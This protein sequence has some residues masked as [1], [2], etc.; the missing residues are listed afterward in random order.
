MGFSA[1]VGGLYR[2]ATITAANLR[3]KRNAVLLS[4][5]AAS[6]ESYP[7][8][9]IAGSLLTT[10]PTVRVTTS[11]SG[12]LIVRV[13][14]NWVSELAGRTLYINGVAYPPTSTWKYNSAVSATQY[15][16]DVPGNIFFSAGSTYLIETRA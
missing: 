4:G 3:V 5:Y 15:I 11:P 9:S 14:G 12:Q 2:R 1:Y 13:S 16:R 7:G 8:G 6:G 10:A